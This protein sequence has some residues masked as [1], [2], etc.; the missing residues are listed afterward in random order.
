MLPDVPD[1]DVR[2]GYKHIKSAKHR[3]VLKPMRCFAFHFI[4][5]LMS[6]SSE[7]DM[8]E[9]PCLLISDIQIVCILRLHSFRIYENVKFVRQGTGIRREIHLHPAEQS[10][11]SPTASG[12]V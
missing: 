2:S 10:V 4:S 9:F 5:Y 12:E 8:S 1:N 11:V 7:L 6:F 3:K